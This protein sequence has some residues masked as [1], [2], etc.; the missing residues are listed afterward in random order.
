MTYAE[1][2]VSALAFNEFIV[3]DLSENYEDYTS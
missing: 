3:I 1:K 2:L